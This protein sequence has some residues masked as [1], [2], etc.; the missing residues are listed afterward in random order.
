MKKSITNLTEHFTGAAS[1]AVVGMKLRELDVLAPV[2]ELVQIEQKTMKDT[3]FDKLQDAFISMLAGASGLVEINTGLR[4]DSALQAAFGRSRCAEQSVVQE[5]LSACRATNVSQMEQALEQIYQRHG[6]GSRHDYRRAFQILDVDLTGIPCGPK[7]ALATKGYFAHQHNR[8]GRQLGRVLATRYDEVVV[9]RLFEGRT[10]L[11][12]AFVPLVQAAERT[13]E[14]SEAKRARTLLRV[15]AGGGSLEDVN[16]A[17]CQGYQFLGKDYSG[18]RARRLAQTVPTWVDDPKEPGRQAGWV[19]EPA[20]EYV[21]EVKRIAIRKRKANGQWAVVVLISTLT[22]KNLSDVG[23]RASAAPLDPQAFLLALVSLYDQRGGGV[24]TSFKGDKQGLGLARRN[25]KRFE[26]QQMVMLLG[27]LAHNVIIWARNWLAE[28]A[29]PLRR[30]GM[31]RMV[32]DVFHISG[33]LLLD[34]WGR[35]H[36]V[37]LNHL[38]PLA[39]VLLAPFQELFASEHVSITLAQT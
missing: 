15:D 31:L 29:S 5:T 28:S 13:L 23:N 35:I 22:P 16:W 27:S 14:L 24:E 10:K 7:A 33:F 32:R 25:K 2:R 11:A 4:A 37:V 1:L 18:Q 38:A 17:L 9:D 26:A 39:S 19:E 6:Q 3:P 21:R 34:V 30:Y 8:R 36:Q 12:E 20:N